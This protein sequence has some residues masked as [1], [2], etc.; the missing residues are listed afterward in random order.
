MDAKSS[1]PD[2]VLLLNQAVAREIKVSIQ[3]MFQHVIWVANG[4]SNAN[5]KTQSNFVGSHRQIWMPGE[6]L[7]KIAITEMR[8]AEAIGERVVVLG[9][10]PTTEIDPIVMGDSIH[11][12]LEIDL[13]EEEEA[14]KLYQNIIHQAQEHN[15]QE[16]LKLFTSIL[17][18]EQ[19]HFETFSKM[20]A[21]E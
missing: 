20:L 19:K 10:K 15:D 12:I 8:H 21:A 14:I 5:P 11:E 13:K 16:T 6:S 4:G 2:L 18:D 9:G 1:S 3:Y 7:K 17:A